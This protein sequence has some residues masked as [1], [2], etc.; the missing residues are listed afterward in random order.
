MKKFVIVFSILAL[1]FISGCTQP[2]NGGG[3]PLDV[4]NIQKISV[5]SKPAT[6]LIS[7]TISGVVTLPTVTV[8]PYTGALIPLEQ[9]YD[10]EVQ[11]GVTGSG[12][13]VSSDG[14]IITN[15]HVVSFSDDVVETELLD[16][17]LAEEIALAEELGGATEEVIQIL[18]D[19]VYQ[20]GEVSSKQISISVI[21]GVPVSGVGTVLKEYTADVRKVG[22]P[23][24]GRDVAII[25]ADQRNM[26]TVKLGDSDEMEVG[27]NV[28]AIGYPRV[29]T[30]H[31]Y[32][33]KESVTE[34]S[35][36][37]GIV[38]AEKQMITGFN[39]LQIDAA[40][41]HGNSGGPVFDENGEVIG[42]ATFG[43]IDYSTWQEIQGFNF[44]VPINIAKE[45][46]A[47]INVENTRGSVDEHYE[48]GMIHYWKDEYSE[49]IEE[50]N[51]VKNLFPAHPYVE[52]YMQSSQ[53]KLL[54]SS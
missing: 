49:A 42:I 8:D 54:G 29:A 25:K 23:S 45:F 35:I 17:A 51:I 10:R 1:L 20:Y 31:K 32:L 30:F 12:F 50:L 33:S 40:I 4:S 19:Y 24:P 3:K 2:E 27:D 52:K 39:V 11:S 26:P 44:I 34:P 15:A 53:E 37:Q 16:A 6:V 14:Y 22:A 5:L 18:E 21:M 7:T 41:T 47:E 36:T 28:Y 43:S 38:S 48:A 13:V 9:T 46:M